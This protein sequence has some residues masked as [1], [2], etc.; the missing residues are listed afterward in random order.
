MPNIP[1]LKTER[2][3][4]FGPLLS[5][6]AA[7]RAF[8]DVSDVT[9]GGYR[10]NRNDA[11]VEGILNRDI[12]HWRTKGF[13]MWLLRLTG[14]EKV[15]GGAGLSHLDGWP[16][17]ELTWWLMPTARGKGFATEAS[18]RVIDWAYDA[19]NYDVV[20]TH[21]RDENTPARRLAQRLGGKIARREV[22]PDG[23][24]RDVFALPKGACT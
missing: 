14:T 1:T 17:H 18:R 23:V 12:A 9:V 11:E 6:L 16:S 2:L 7:Y 5:D 20:E 21:M 10:G 15:L 4:L 22:F 13:G 3:T 8:Y 19:L 24:T